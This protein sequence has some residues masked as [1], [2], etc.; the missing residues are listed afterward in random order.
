MNPENWSKP[1]LISVRASRFIWLSLDSLDNPGGWTTLLTS[2]GPRDTLSGL[3]DQW[4]TQLTHLTI[5][6]LNRAWGETTPQRKKCPPARTVDCSSPSEESSGI[7]HYHRWKVIQ[8][9]AL[10]AKGIITA[11]P[12][13]RQWMTQV[14]AIG[15]FVFRS[16]WNFVGLRLESESSGSRF[17]ICDR[18]AMTNL[19]RRSR[20]HAE[21]RTLD[22]SSLE[23][24][25][26]SRQ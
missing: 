13:R 2:Q 14:Q 12:F 19:Y 25:H 15:S 23:I 11:S 22:D 1:P 7:P 3:S 21:V 10:R 6:D 20:L 18:M 24:V 5:S 4:L 16:Y 26:G 17:T 8:S 9:L